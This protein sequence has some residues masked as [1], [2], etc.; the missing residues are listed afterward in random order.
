LRK[1]GAKIL[2]ASDVRCK[3]YSRSSLTSLARQYSQYG[4]WKVRVLQKHSGQMQPRQFV[5]PLFVGAC[6]V[7]LLLLPLTPM[8][9][10]FLG[11]V[12][13]SYAI[14]NL[15]ASLLCVRKNKYGT[16][17]LLS[18]VFATLHVAYGLGF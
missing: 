5:P 17:P 16:L 13:G 15:T 8:A 1:M 3:Y 9:K 12:L 7:L 2:L 4:F 14:A 10:Y 18:I 11:A 6:L